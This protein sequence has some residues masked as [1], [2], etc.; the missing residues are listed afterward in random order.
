VEQE[1]ATKLGRDPTEAEIAI[2]AELLEDQMVGNVFALRFGL[3]GDEPRSL[4]QA[5]AQLGISAERARRPEDQ[6]LG[7]LAYTAELKELRAA[8]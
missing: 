3:T 5:G 8:A 1:L 4:R 2:A 6:A 7:R